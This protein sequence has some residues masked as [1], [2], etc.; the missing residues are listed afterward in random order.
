VYLIFALIDRL[1]FAP[2]TGADDSNNRSAVREPPFGLAVR[3]VLGNHALRVRKGVLGAGKRDSVFSLILGV[4]VGVP[5]QASFC[6]ERRA[7][8]AYTKSHTEIWIVPTFELSRDRQESA[9]PLN[10]ERAKEDGDGSLQPNTG[11]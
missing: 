2:I 8:P 7:A 5:I 6:Y 4:L 9:R 1:S 3:L 10:P 11:R